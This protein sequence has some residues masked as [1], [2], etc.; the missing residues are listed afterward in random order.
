MR[1]RDLPCASYVPCTG[2]PGSYRAS[3]LRHTGLPGSYRASYLRHTGL[4]GSPLRGACVSSF[5]SVGG[6]S[7]RPYRYL[8]TCASE[9]VSVLVSVRM[10][11]GAYLLTCT[12]QRYLCRESNVLHRSACICTCTCAQ[13]AHIHHLHNHLPHL[14]GA[15]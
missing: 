12:A 10:L 15:A 4:L 8:C 2:L 7:T 3:Y 5:Q 1:A 9:C 14:L 6:R 11:S 13:V